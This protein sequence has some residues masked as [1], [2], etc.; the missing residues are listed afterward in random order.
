[1]GD[2]GRPEPSAR[3]LGHRGVLRHGRPGGLGCPRHCRRFFFF[4]FFFFHSGRVRAVRRCRH[5]SEMIRSAREL[6]VDRPKRCF[7]VNVAPDLALFEAGTFDFVLSLIVLQHMPSGQA[8]PGYLAEF[9]R[10]LRPGGLLVFQIHRDRVPARR[11]APSWL[12]EPARELSCRSRRPPLAPDGR[13]PRKVERS[14]RERWRGRSAAPDHLAGGLGLRP[15]V[16]VRSP[17]PGHLPRA[18]MRLPS[19]KR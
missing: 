18:M 14:S 8:A 12:Q 11:P 2:P 9:L 6:N 1:M 17:Q 10:V 4:F 19:S 13:C 7:L 15:F 3:A 16:G 5:L